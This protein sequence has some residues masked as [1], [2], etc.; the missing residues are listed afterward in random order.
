MPVGCKLFAREGLWVQGIMH[1]TEGLREM[2]LLFNRAQGGEEDVK[3]YFA[4]ASAMLRRTG[5]HSTFESSS[6]SYDLRRAKISI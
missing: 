2:R 3:T 1:P 5:I 4:S 6:R